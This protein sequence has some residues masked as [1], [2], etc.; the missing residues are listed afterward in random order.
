MY[1]DR[2]LQDPVGRLGIHYVQYAVDRL[3][4]AD[5]QNRGSEYLV[6]LGIHQIFMKPLVSPF[7]T[8]R[9]TRVI[10]RIP[11]RIL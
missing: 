4:P 9:P 8:A 11:M 6:G 10:G 1:M 7:S 2:V 3:I 5:A